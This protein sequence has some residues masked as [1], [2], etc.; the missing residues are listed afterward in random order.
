[1]YLKTYK[2]QCVNFGTYFSENPVG[3]L[4][5]WNFTLWE[6][7]VWGTKIANMSHHVF[8]YLLT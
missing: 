6:K 2:V 1:M 3:D 7:Q 5:L 4:Q 8:L